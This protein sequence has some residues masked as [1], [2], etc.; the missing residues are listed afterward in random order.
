MHLYITCPRVLYPAQK[1]YKYRVFYGPYLDAF[2]A[3][4]VAIY[5]TGVSILLV[6]RITNWITPSI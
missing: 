6:N 4:L 2:H 1:L 5:K 3:Y